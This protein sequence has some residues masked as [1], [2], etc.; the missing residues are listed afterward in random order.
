MELVDLDNGK[1]IHMKSED[2]FSKNGLIVAQFTVAERLLFR[3]LDKLL[4][5]R[6]FQPRL[7]IVVQP[8]M[9]KEDILSEVE[10]RAIL[11]LCERAGGSKI[12]IHESDI[13]LTLQEARKII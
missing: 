13:K 11:E 2:K 10:K 3:L 12:L 6:I 5:K 9:H 1:S 8:K 4:K 7:D